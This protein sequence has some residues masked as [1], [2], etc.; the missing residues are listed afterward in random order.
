MTRSSFYIL[1][2]V[3]AGSLFLIAGCGDRVEQGE[4]AETA[5]LI[6]CDPVLMAPVDIAAKENETILVIPP[7]SRG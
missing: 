5:P 6:Q 1:C 3:L 2:G 4:A 7:T